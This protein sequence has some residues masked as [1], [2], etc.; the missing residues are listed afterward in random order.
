MKNEIKLESEPRLSPEYLSYRRVY[1]V[2]F[3]QLS[4]VLCNFESLNIDMTKFSV[5]LLYM[6]MA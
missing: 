1:T 4:P 6:D 3:V 5:E 2:T